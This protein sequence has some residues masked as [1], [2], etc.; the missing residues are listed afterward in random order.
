MSS[1]T[2]HSLSHLGMTRAALL[3]NLYPPREG[4]EANKTWVQAI[5]LTLSQY[6]DRVIL[7]VTDPLKGLPSTT[8]FQPSVAEVRECCEQW[9]EVFSESSKYEKAYKER[10]SKQLAERRKYE[11]KYPSAWVERKFYESGELS[12][13]LKDCKARGFDPFKKRPIGRFETAEQLSKWQK[14][15]E[16][17]AL[18][19]GKKEEEKTATESKSDKGWQSIADLTADIERLFGEAT[20][21]ETKW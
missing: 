12:D 7:R 8:K 19:F 3:L 13:F 6:E 4:E 15:P 16:G 11:E 14:V 21:K 18:Q 1:E 5:A 10:V 17:E 9:R 2:M 20:K